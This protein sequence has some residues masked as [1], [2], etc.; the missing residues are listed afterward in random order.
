MEMNFEI[1]SSVIL[2][3]QIGGCIDPITA[4]TGSAWKAFHELLPILKNKGIS[5]LSHGKVFEACA[6]SVLLY[7]SEK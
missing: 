2:L 6:R 7:G 3:G 4:S 5:L 1:V